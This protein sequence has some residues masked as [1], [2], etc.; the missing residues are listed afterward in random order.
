MPLNK[1]LNIK[2]WRCQILFVSLQTESTTDRLTD[3]N[4]PKKLQIPQ[5]Q[6]KWQKNIPLSPSGTLFA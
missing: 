4:H 3:K 2:I 1:Q 6:T 5:N